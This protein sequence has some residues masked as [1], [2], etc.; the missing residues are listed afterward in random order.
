[1]LL[2]CSIGCIDEIVAIHAFLSSHANMIRKTKIVKS[3]KHLEW[4]ARNHVCL[5]CRSNYGI[6]STHILEKLIF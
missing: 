4:V 3:R 2:F 5:R 1:M 6:Q